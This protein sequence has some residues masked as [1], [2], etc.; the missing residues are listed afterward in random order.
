M[1]DYLIMFGIFMAVTVMAGAVIFMMADSKGSTTE[2]RL[3]ILTKQKSAKAEDQSIMKE[4]L[5]GAGGGI[6]QSFAKMLERVGNLGLFL[7]Q[8]DSP[9]R[10]DVFL[11]LSGGFLFVGTGVG[12]ASHAPLPLWPVFAIGFSLMPFAWLWWRRR[13]RFKRFA[14]QLP[15]AMELIARALRSGHSLNSGI[16][17]VVEEMPEPIAVEF[18]L[19][20]EEQNLGVPI[21]IALKNM[22]KRMPN[23]DLKF[24]V[25]AVAIQKQAGGDLSEILDKIRYIIRERFKIMGMVMALTGEGRMSG[26]VLQAMPIALFLVLYYMNPGYVMILFEEELGKTML[27]YALG[28]QMI[29]AFVIKK[30][31]AIKV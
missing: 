14:R 7:E 12:W 2:D 26:I 22:L 31:V 10:P 1:D 13:G 20:Y 24:F 18:M 28:L 8:A 5:M 15:D 3:E 11:M 9:I 19:A 27:M 21:D 29:G 4:D 25:T 6:T 17:V 23:M 30:I 16:N